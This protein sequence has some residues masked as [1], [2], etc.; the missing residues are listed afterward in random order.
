[1]GNLKK[2]LVV[3]TQ[4][5]CRSQMAEGFLK[6]K[7]KGRLQVFSAGVEPT[8]VNPKA[9]EVMKEIGIDISDQRSKAMQEVLGRHNFAYVIFVCEKAEQTCPRIY[10]T[11][12]GELIS[13]PF[14]D[15]ASFTGSE[16][17][18]MNK[19]RE[20]RDKIG[21]KIDQWLKEID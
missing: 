15:P 4:N 5:A 21:E 12:G 17:E 9:I 7:A 3:C 1:M 14:D 10:P 8:E 13:W 11:I 20:V 2:A 18:V 19:F 16:E 6:N